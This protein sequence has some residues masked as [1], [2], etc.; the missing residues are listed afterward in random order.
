MALFHYIKLKLNTQWK[1]QQLQ[2][3]LIQWLLNASGQ[4]KEQN[5]V[6]VAIKGHTFCVGLVVQG[7][8]VQSPGP[9]T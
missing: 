4:K 1:P 3:Q 7:S 2:E 8:A 5:C 6:H 9:A